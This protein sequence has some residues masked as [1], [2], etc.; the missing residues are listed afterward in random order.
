MRVSRKQTRCALVLGNGRYPEDATLINATND[1]TKISESLTRLGFE[2]FTGLDLTITET[3]SLID[4]FL[5]FLQQKGKFNVALIFFSGHGIQDGNINYL[6][7]IDANRSGENLIHLQ[8]LIE[9]VTPHSSRRVVFLDACRSYSEA[10]ETINDLHRSKGIAIDGKVVTQAG[11]P[12]IEVSTDTFLAFAAAPGKQAFDG[13]SRSNES[14]GLSPFSGALIKHIESVDV[15]ITNLMTRV[16]NSV[17][18]ETSNRQDTWDSS[19]LT[20]TFFFNPSSLLLLIGNSLGLL[21]LFFA[22]I[23]YSFRLSEKPDAIWI[24]ICLSVLV[25]VLVLFLSGLHRAYSRM[26]G[27]VSHED[28]DKSSRKQFR[29]H[30]KNGATG[31]VFGATIS[32]MVIAIP[33]WSEWHL[34]C[35]SL[36]AQTEFSLDEWNYLYLFCA[37]PQLGRLM[38]E[39]MVAAI[40]ISS[41]LGALALSYALKFSPENNTQNSSQRLLGI[42]KGAMFGGL[43]AG[44]ITMPFITLY[45]GR[46]DRP[47]FHPLSAVIGSTIISS[48][49]AFSIV[50]Y[51]LEKFSRRRLFQSAIAAFIATLATYAVLAPFVWGL[52]VT[53]VIDVIF[54]W[55]NAGYYAN[56][57]EYS[58]VAAFFLLGGGLV[59][60]IVFGPFLGF[61][62]GF[63][64]WATPRH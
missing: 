44:M 21:A 28:S 33:Y 10:Q 19:S 29:R 51:S 34:K 58:L 49:I 56:K 47:F 11:M 2:V 45:F 27:E 62:I 61:L 54:D 41:V 36:L 3:Q 23:P 17:A 14:S 53:S 38:T 9:K 59:Y 60:G 16:R 35:Q 20:E 31:G 26:R 5:L 43:L 37:A 8:E 50:N 57:D 1:A 25:L 48:T 52:E 32:A 6:V 18:R 39:T 46:F 42:L 12:E 40:I 55:S 7:P 13:K 4:Q 22:A 30:L 64:L 24:A 15:P 63:T